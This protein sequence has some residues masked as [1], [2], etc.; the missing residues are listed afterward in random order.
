M[1]ISARGPR[2]LM[3]RLFATSQPSLGQHTV[4][5]LIRLELRAT[6]C[7]Y[8]DLPCVLT[9]AEATVRK[10]ESRG[11]ESGPEMGPLYDTYICEE[12]PLLRCCLCALRA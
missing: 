4:A 11:P 2:V 9:V 12:V 6:L 10:I 1:Q 7:P 5:P 8:G 3:L